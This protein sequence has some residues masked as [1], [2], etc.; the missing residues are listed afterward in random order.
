MAELFF[1]YVH[2]LENAVGGEQ[3]DVALIEDR[4]LAFGELHVLEH[5]ERQPG[6]GELV[7]NAA[8]RPVDL[9]VLVPRARV[10]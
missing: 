2:G 3:K 8:S 1:V 9:W 10:S 6:A 4:R 7:D 5:A